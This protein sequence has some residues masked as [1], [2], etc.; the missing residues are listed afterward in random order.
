M[1]FT[2]FRLFRLT[3][4]LSS[5]GCQTRPVALANQ[6]RSR[7]RLQRFVRR[8]PLHGD[9]KHRIPNSARFEKAQE[10]GQADTRSSLAQQHRH[11]LHRL[12]GRRVL[13]ILVTT[14][15]SYTTRFDSVT[16]QPPNAQAQQ[17]RLPDAT[18]GPGKP[19][20]Q[21]RSAAALC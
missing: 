15:T 21:P 3:P 20:P 9:L 16:T 8:N 14:I 19:I 6:Y 18:R 1:H 12:H 11:C 17:P 10:P 13:R 7:G 4:K 5:R 2:P